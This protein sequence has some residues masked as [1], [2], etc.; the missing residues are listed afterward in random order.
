MSLRVVQQQVIGLNQ[1]AL[2]EWIAYRREDCKKPMNQRAVD[3]VI[4]KLLRYSEEEQER[5]IDHAIEMEWQGI[6]Y[7]EPQ[8]VQ[9][10]RSS[11]IADDLNDTSWAK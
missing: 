10:S 11:S 8:R 3:R 6:Y 2:D 9:D 7:V 4:K 1:A 5:L